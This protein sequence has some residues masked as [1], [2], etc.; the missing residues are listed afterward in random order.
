MIPHRDLL[1]GGLNLFSDGATK[2]I[3]LAHNN[4]DLGSRDMLNVL[5][6]P[7]CIKNWDEKAD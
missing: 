5:S 1:S 2:K 6:V 3:T 7:V 4:E